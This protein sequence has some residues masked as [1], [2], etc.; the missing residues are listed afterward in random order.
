MAHPKPTPGSGTSLTTNIYN[1]DNVRKVLYYGWEGPGQWN[2]FTSKEKGV[3][4]TSLALSYY[5]YG[6]KS[7]KDIDEFL[8]YVKNKTVPNFD[9]KF[10]K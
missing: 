5:Y 2:G 9:V 8:D 3:V 7:T 4:I 10:N 6:D 1:N